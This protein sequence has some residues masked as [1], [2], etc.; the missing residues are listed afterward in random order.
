MI[1]SKWSVWKQ[2]TPPASAVNPSYFIVNLTPCPICW[3]CFITS[4]HELL[5]LWAGKLGIQLRLRLPPPQKAW[6]ALLGLPRPQFHTPCGQSSH[7][8]FLLSV[9]AWA[10]L[11][12]VPSF[13]WWQKLATSYSTWQPWAWITREHRIASQLLTISWKAFSGGSAVKNLPTMQETLVQSLGLEDLLEEDM[14]THSN[15]LAWRIPWT[16]EP[17]GL[18]SIGVSKSQTRLMST[19]TFKPLSMT[20]RFSC[21]KLKPQL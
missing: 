12:E 8:S 9:W 5:P 2:V 14:A 17:G 21:L 20:W 7:S 4:S 16:E 15:I 11:S 13:P 1:T 10:P 3:A 19:F 18:Q 6:P